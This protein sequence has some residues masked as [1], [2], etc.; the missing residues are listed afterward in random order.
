MVHENWRCGMIFA[1]PDWWRWKLS[2]LSIACP[3]NSFHR[4]RLGIKTATVHAAASTIPDSKASEM[5]LPEI[6][7]RKT[8][9]AVAGLGALAV[10]QVLPAFSQ[11]R[12][13]ELAALV[14]GDPEK[15]AHLG[16]VYQVPQ[17]RQFAYEDYDRLL[18]RDD[19][20]AIYIVLPNTL[21]ADYTIRALR[22]GKHVL[23]E[24]PMA[25]TL[26]ECEAMNLAAQQEGAKLMIAYRL[27][28]EPLNQKVVGWMK[29]S[30]FGTLQS[31][32]SANTQMT[33]APDIRLQA[34]LG[35]GP[36]GDLGIYSINA[37]RYITGE[38]PDRVYAVANYPDDS[39][40][41]EVPSNVTFTLTFP[42]GVQACCTCGFDSAVHRSYTIHC[43]EGIVWMDP[44]FSY[45][46]LRLFYNEDGETVKVSSQSFNQFANEMDE[47]A[48]CILED[49]EP[50]SNGPEG[51][52]DV[53][54]IAAIH[55]SIQTGESV[56]L[57]DPALS[58]DYPALTLGLQ[59]V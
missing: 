15:R 7:D 6:V 18:D 48:R 1:I 12:Y 4:P 20:D 42:S 23:C 43:S 41:R 3:K 51:V 46:G 8:R 16:K 10:E 44:A 52:K 38:E 17:D 2:V 9:W 33:S 45:D 59:T 11:A 32:V 28:Y 50:M 49:R 22:A 57:D 27:Q 37:A 35:G 21:H 58:P 14:S 5:K 47:L 34:N 30:R 56:A 53:R 39:R 19:V 26:G 36:V 13:C 24:K 25:P 29:E 40:F 54:I 55:R 31:I